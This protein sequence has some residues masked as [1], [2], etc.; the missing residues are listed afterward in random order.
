MAEALHL[1]RLGDGSMC[2]QRFGGVFL[3]GNK[4]DLSDQLAP[5]GGLSL[6]RRL[7]A[8]LR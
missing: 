4:V 2:D 3:K 1:Q 7:G 5:A 6:D 8:N